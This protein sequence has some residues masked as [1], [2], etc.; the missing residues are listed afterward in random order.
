VLTKRAGLALGS[1]DVMV[2]VVGGLK[3]QEPA[4]D[5]SAA[6]AI[7]SSFKDERIAGDLVEVGEVGLSGELRSCA[8]LDRRLAE[9]AKLGFRRCI[10]P[11]TAWRRGR[12][13][14]PLELLAARSVGDA[15]QLALGAPLEAARVR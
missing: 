2:N 7:A 14:T 12:P 13:Y 3:L 4:I 8:H 1:Q 10:L 9:A 5:L 15:I 11:W 6:L